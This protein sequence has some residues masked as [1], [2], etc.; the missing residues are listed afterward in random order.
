MNKK[1]ALI[2]AAVAGVLAAGVLAGLMV[3]S[4]AAGGDSSLEGTWHLTSWSSADPIVTADGQPVT[5]TVTGPEVAGFS[6]CNRYVGPA[7]LSGT[8]FKLSGPL[9]S[10]MMACLN[11]TAET[12]YLDL[13]AKADS[14]AI[15]GGTLTLSAGGQVVLT[16]VRA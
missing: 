12:T 7:T 1:L 2:A 14:W 16:Y 11:D 4:H 13:L 8:G 9:A 5:L 6:G 3:V 15:S 10:T